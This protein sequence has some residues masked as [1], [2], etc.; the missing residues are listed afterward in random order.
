M[1]LDQLLGAEQS[2]ISLWD[3]QGLQ[4]DVHK[5][6]SNFQLPVDNASA[7]DSSSSTQAF[8]QGRMSTKWVSGRQLSFSSCIS[9]S[10]AL[11]QCSHRIVGTSRTF[12][13][14]DNCLA[15]IPGHIVPRVLVNEIVVSASTGT[16]STVSLA[17]TTTTVAAT[18]TIRMNL[19]LRSIPTTTLLAVI[20]VVVIAHICTIHISLLRL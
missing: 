1:L 3:M 14:L 2:V 11:V 15:F 5:L 9:N 17:T 16:T 6:V 4:M 20:V 18:T 8:Q 13:C 7:L 12:A 19:P 10:L